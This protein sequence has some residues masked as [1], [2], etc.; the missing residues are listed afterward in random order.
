MR[1][2]WRDASRLRR[3][4]MPWA[5]PPRGRTTVSGGAKL[6]LMTMGVLVGQ[7]AGGALTGETSWWAGVLG[8]AGTIGA[9]GGW[10]ASGRHGRGLV[11]AGIG[12]GA[13]ALGVLQMQAVAAP[14]LP[15]CHVAHLKLPQRAVLQARV[16][17][18]PERHGGRTRLLVESERAGGRRAC[19]LVRVTV[20]RASRP[21]RYGDRFRAETTLRQPRNFANPGSYDLVGR[22][23]RQGVHVTAFVWDDA[24]VQ[25]RPERRTS[26]RLRVERWRARVTEII[27]R[28]PSPHGPVLQ[29]LV[30]GD[31]GGID[32]TLRERFARSGVVHVLSI[33]GL[34]VGLVAVTVF[35]AVRWLLARSECILL[36]V[37]VRKVAA[38][39]SLG[40]VLLYAALAGWQLATVRSVVMVAVAVGGVLLGRPVEV[41]RTLAAAALAIA[42]M[43]PG[44]PIEI[45]FQLSFASV[46]AIIVGVRWSGGAGRGPARGLGRVARWLR[47]AS[48]VSVWALLGTAPL[49]AFHFHQVSLVAVVANPVVVPLFGSVVVGL[50]LTGALVEPIAPAVAWGLLQAAGV[51]LRPAIAVVQT[52]GA[53]PWAAVDTPIPSIVELVLVYATIAGVLLLP[54]PQGRIVLVA[55]LVGL[56]MDAGW[57]ARYRWRSGELRV[58]FLDVG[59]GDAAVLEFPN[60]RVMTVDAGGMAGG[61]L[62]TG[63]AVVGPFLWSRKIL[64]LDAVVVTHAHPDHFGGV[65]YL[66]ERFAPRELWWPGTDGTGDAWRR[67]SAVM[68]EK[69]IRSRVLGV[70][71]LV[72]GFGADLAVLNPDPTVLPESV[73]DTSVTLQVTFGRVRVLLTGDIEAPTERRLVI[74][75]E[76]ASATVLKVP[77]HGSRTSST[78]SF[79]ARVSPRIAVVSVGADNRYGLPAPE[80]EARYRAAGGCV[81][82]TDDCGAVTVRTDGRRV[83]VATYRPTCTCP[84]FD[85]GREAPVLVS[86]TPR[87]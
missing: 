25:A 11:G 19:G 47:E 23:A 67:L 54:R 66:L 26:M 62:D 50:G 80:V 37:D 30:V 43:W 63:A 44:A 13:F 32:D 16:V 35:G 69:V 5:T 18:P 85:L 1:R 81:L 8:V 71:A 57:W 10:I 55:A 83:R 87:G 49:T 22:L 45:A 15:P 21:W 76:L 36:A 24:T 7:W 65:P 33:S 4:H 61:D 9:F 38:V 52:L 40:P 59:Q 64:G 31:A 84:E 2:A 12:A 72:P 77:H 48:M 46:L 41:L 70:G 6:G 73:N 74:G 51:L 28:V 79:V 78:P 82:R 34:H 58:T 14:A 86:V 20:R 56:L 39:V 3:V 68:Q 27:A 29:A 75:D 60:G 53:L 17:A 42:L